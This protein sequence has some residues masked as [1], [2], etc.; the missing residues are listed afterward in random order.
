[1]P[2]STRLTTRLIRGTVDATTTSKVVAYLCGGLGN[3]LFIYAAA[4]RLAHVHGAELVLDDVS[5][6]ARD[7][8]FQRFYQLDH[9]HVRGRKA[10]PAE[11]FEPC[12]RIRRSIVRRINLRRPF[13]Q[14]S[15]V[16]QEGRGF[17]S[18]LLSFAPRGTVHLEGLWQDERYF[19][20][21]EPL[22]R[23][24]LVIKPPRDP[25]NRALASEIRDTNAVAVHVRFFEDIGA[26]EI[27][28]TP[29]G[30]YKRAVDFVMS[31]VSSPRFYVFS[32]QPESVLQRLALPKHSTTVVGLN[33]GDDGAY[34][35]MWLM[36]HCRHFIIANSTFSWWAAWLGASPHAMVLAPGRPS[37][38]AHSWGFEGIIPD[39]WIRI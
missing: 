13:P 26:A 36:T 33:R 24:D 30:Y 1:V 9:F 15:Y 39:R 27:N 37:Q 5:G 11:R 20:D 21:A 32:D 28:N 3:Q 34:A 7:H 18:R 8:D 6:F 4:M 31:R 2:A 23:K 17:D 19:Q 16:F 29:A 12:S 38:N 10:T 25:R 22:L 14:R 35:D